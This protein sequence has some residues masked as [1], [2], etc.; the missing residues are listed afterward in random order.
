M[1]LT[2]PE[3]EP[4]S[5]ALSGELNAA[6]TSAAESLPGNRRVL[7][8]A[9]VFYAITKGKGLGGS[10]I[11]TFAQD[12]EI[13]QKLQLYFEDK[14]HDIESD[15]AE[16]GTIIVNS[17]QVPC[18]SSCLSLFNEA[19]TLGI[20]ANNIDT[21]HILIADVRRSDSYMEQV[22]QEIGV[23]DTPLKSI[24]EKF[25]S[26][27]RTRMSKESNGSTI[28]IKEG[29]RTYDFIK[30]A[31]EGNLS[32]ITVKNDWIIAT[33]TSIDTN[34]MSVLFTNHDDEATLIIHALAN[35]LS[36]DDTGVLGYK[37]LIVPDVGYLAED[38]DGTLNEA[39]KRAK[40][41]ILVI[42]A[43]VDFLQ[44][45]KLKAALKRREIKVLAYSS[46]AD[47]LKY[48]KDV[49]DRI[50]T[51]M[52]YLSPMTVEETETTIQSQ[53]KEIEA[54][55]NTANL[56]L[57]ITPAA[58]HEAVKLA[59]RYNGVLEMSVL[60]GATTL[61]ERAGSMVKFANSKLSAFSNGKIIKDLSIDPADIDVALKELKDI[62]VVDDNR[63]RY[64][65]MEDYLRKRVIGQEDAIK[66]VSNA[67]RKA[68]AGLKDP[69]RPIG[70]FLF[71][72]PSGVGKTELAKALAEFLFDDDA[73]MIRIDM[74]EYEEKHTVSRLIGAPPGYVGYEEGGQ[75][76]EA[77]RRKP[78]SVVTF[79]E[80]EKAHPDIWNT[81]LQVMDDGR[82][83]DGKG[84]TVDFRNTVIILTGNVGSEYFADLA[85]S[86]FAKVKDQVL[87]KVI[88]T[89]RP[90]F[91]NRLDAQI[92]FKSLSKED[93]GSI[94]ALQIKKV[95]KKLAEQGI[96]LEITP[97][98]KDELIQ[99]GY[100]PKYGVRPLQRAVQA[101][102]EDNLAIKLMSSEFTT[103]D[104]IITDYIDGA[105]TFT[106]KSVSPK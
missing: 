80:V 15:G 43:S 34:G 48:Q 39:I 57:T 35:Q 79:D 2:S 55:I 25:V 13:S 72:G 24:F 51:G 18:T 23:K 105:V 16:F 5:I 29:V 21:G 76:T 6:L 89:F 52:I 42:P 61:I 31:K 59:H 81:L 30:L 49:R 54:F 99:K 95:N 84:R 33:L 37:N 40:G 96:A 56:K 4:Q 66:I 44:N 64:L 22:F 88:N 1:P 36:Q 67:V 82:L 47:W 103:G 17:Q 74:S 63:E 8:V 98:M 27:A 83:T 12:K 65:Q 28:T 86:G 85:K 69:N 14:I 32:S 10:V 9:D 71:V 45:P 104:N 26:I 90:E 77:V 75:L 101:L 68:R 70:N 7:G 38:L 91:L 97:Q 106:K 11:N 92:V 53:V 73:A 78:Y 60:T 50:E 100:D 41:G 87:Q 102:I 3:K 46:E 58:I 20:G 94:V 19:M 93:I 62:D